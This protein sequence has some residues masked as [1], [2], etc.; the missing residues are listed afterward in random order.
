MKKLK[1]TY[2]AIMAGGAGTRF[3]PR[4]KS[5]FPKQFLDIL[6][7]GKTLLQETFERASSLVDNENILVLTNQ[8]YVTI[9]REQL[10]GIHNDNIL[11][12]PL[13]KNTGP[14]LMFLTY[15]IHQKSPDASLI[16]IPSDHLIGD[17]ATYN[18]SI[19]TAVQFCKEN[20]ALVTLGI[21]PS[22]PHT[23]YGYIQMGEQQQ[24]PSIYKV[25]T[26]TE[27]PSLELAQ[28]FVEIGEFLWN[29]GIFIWTVESALRAMTQYMLQETEIFKKDFVHYMNSAHDKSVQQKWLHSIFEKCRNISIDYA[30]LEYAKNVFVVASDFEWNDLGSWTTVYDLQK[31]DDNGNACINEHMAV[32]LNT[33]NCLVNVGAQKLVVIDGLE[34]YMVLDTNEALLIC[35]KADAQKIK[36]YL[37]IIKEKG[38]KDYL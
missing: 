27:K 16:I 35:K 12:E 36:D 4:S 7:T 1:N 31:K 34:D 11:A 24:H 17:Q 25:K 29:A 10:P 22:S 28:Q 32:L 20:D 30:L 19:K 14:C 6:G 3:W 18:N 8:Q 9:V 33:S 21:Q 38:K 37:N 15:L 2:I 13:S 5:S 26:F 23:G